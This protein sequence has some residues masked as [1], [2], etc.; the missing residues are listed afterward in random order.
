ME[1]K[2]IRTEQNGNIGTLTINRPEKQNALS[3]EL[4]MQ[5]HQILQQWANEGSIRALVI[6]GSGEASFSSGFDISSIPTKMSQETT[7]ALKAENPLEM[8]LADVKSFPFPTIAMMNGNAF[9]AG[10][11]LA[12][13]CDIRI[14]ANH[15]K[16]G[17]P[18]AKLGLIYHPEGLKQFVEVLGMT[19]ARE[20]FFTAHTYSGDMLNELKIF[21]RLVPKSE[22]E[23]TTYKIAAKISENAPLALKGTKSMFLMLEN[24]VTFSDADKKTAEALII[25]GFNSQDLKEARSAFLEKR[26]AVFCGR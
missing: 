17:M 19:A 22:L 16:I 1:N 14:A 11:N 12:L 20:M 24:A 21:S 15:I 3:P 2:L 18:A 23:A 7:V 25:E 5:F 26:K 8:V 4:L 10:L 13:C 6:T 9:G